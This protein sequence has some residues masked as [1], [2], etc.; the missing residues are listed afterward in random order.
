MAMSY[1]EIIEDDCGC[2]DGLPIKILSSDH[3]K[4]LIGKYYKKRIIDREWSLLTESDTDLIGKNITI[5]SPMTCQ[6]KNF[7]ICKKCFGEKR[8]RTKYIGVTAGQCITERLT[9]LLLRS[10]HTSGSCELTIDPIV[11]N[12]IRDHLIDITTP[13]KA[14]IKLIFDGKEKIPLNFQE[15]P[16]FLGIENN[17]ALFGLISE[18]VVNN[19]TLSTVVKIKELLRKN[20]K[21]ILTPSDYYQ[22]FIDCILSVGGIYLC[23]VQEN[24]GI[25]ARD[26]LQHS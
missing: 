18:D 11:S 3:F 12:F 20:D 17:A 24:P 22:D 19:D 10:F 13:N 2:K 7:K 8:T 15:I 26:E 25:H 9:Q 5:R 21:V 14:S 23:N 1:I 6:T 16:G 4:T